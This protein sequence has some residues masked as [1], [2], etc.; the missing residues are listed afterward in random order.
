VNSRFCRDIP[1]SVFKRLRILIKLHPN[2]QFCK[3]H[4]NNRAYCLHREAQLQANALQLFF[5]TLE[6]DEDAYFR[7][8]VHIVT[9]AKLGIKNGCKQ[10]VT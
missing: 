5:L 3:L 4:T 6:Q 2:H 10:L 8:F 9:N 1:A 7:E